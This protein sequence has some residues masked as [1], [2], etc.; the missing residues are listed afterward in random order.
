MER[1]LERLSQPERHRLLLAS[2]VPRPIAFVSTL[3]ASGVSNLAPFSYFNVVAT[4][5]ALISLSIGQRSWQGERQKKDTLQNIEAIGEFV[6]NVA[7]EALL[8]QVNQASAEYPPGVSEIDATGLTPIPAQRVRP[9][10]IAECPIHLECILRQV[11]SLGDS[12]Q[13]GLV[14]G[15]VVHYHAADDVL[16]DAGELPDP[17]RLRPLARL[18]GS[19]YSGLGPIHSRARPTEPR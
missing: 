16:D 7:T 2:V 9:P 11:I 15:E 12:P 19:L 1:E 8:D 3:D 6:V 13:V 17:N 4:R 14:I 10:R 5:P 18:G